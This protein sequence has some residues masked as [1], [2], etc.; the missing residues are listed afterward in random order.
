MVFITVTAKGVKVQLC[1]IDARE[2]RE[3]ALLF[4]KIC[5]AVEQLRRLIGK[6]QERAPVLSGNL[7]E[8]LDLKTDLATK[9]EAVGGRQR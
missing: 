4:A 6:R 3:A 7:A 5:P 2:E 1:G 9:Q 8:T